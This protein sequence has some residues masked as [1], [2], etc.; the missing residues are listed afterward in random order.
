VSSIPLP[1][2]FLFLAAHHFL[3]YIVANST[4][5]ISGAIQ[6]IKYI[7]SYDS[8][9]FQYFEIEILEI[10]I[11]RLGKNCQ[12]ICPLWIGINLSATRERD[13]GWTGAPSVYCRVFTDHPNVPCK[14]GGQI[15]GR[16][17]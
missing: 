6:G 12:R 14:G 17:L 3:P 10:I 7:P 1:L 15:S 8:F 4:L 13:F 2:F 16:L 9:H 5:F 11:A